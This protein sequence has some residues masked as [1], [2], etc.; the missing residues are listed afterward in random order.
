MN[1]LIGPRAQKDRN[2]RL[3]NLDGSNPQTII[4][5]LM[6][7]SKVTTNEFLSLPNKITLSI[8]LIGNK[9]WGR[10]SIFRIQQ[11]AQQQLAS[12]PPVP[13]TEISFFNFKTLRLMC[14]LIHQKLTQN[15]SRNKFPKK[16]RKTFLVVE[17]L[18]CWGKILTNLWPSDQLTVKNPNK[19]IKT[20]HNELQFT[21]K[22]WLHLAVMFIWVFPQSVP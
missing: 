3:E 17:V 9:W 15:A 13:Q 5:S 22:K 6:G 20:K 11:I 18:N 4:Q 1:L 7:W 16:S 12:I 2:S 19:N 21:L 8:Y 14:I 10:S